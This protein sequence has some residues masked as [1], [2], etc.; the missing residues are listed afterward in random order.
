MVSPVFVPGLCGRVGDGFDHGDAAD[1]WG[2]APVLGDV[3]EH[4]L[5]DLVPP[6]R[7]SWWI[8]ADLEGQAGLV[9]KPLRF[10]FPQPQPR[11]VRA[12][13]IGGDH[14]CFAAG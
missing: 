10:K 3:A 1:A 8:V 11:T 5:L 7:G 6:L 13:A 14:A 2:C 12:T 4:A 9:G